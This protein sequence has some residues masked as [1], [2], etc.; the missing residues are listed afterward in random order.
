MT[1]LATSSV[2]TSDPIAAIAAARLSYSLS[3]EM[4]MD[5]SRCAQFRAMG[6]EGD[7]PVPDLA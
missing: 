4:L 7:G 5:P 6:V 1:A 3:D 2:R